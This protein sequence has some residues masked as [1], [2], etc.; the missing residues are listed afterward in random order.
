[1]ATVHS[2]L[3]QLW[4]D[5]NTCILLFDAKYDKLHRKPSFNETN[6]ELE[7]NV[8][9]SAL[10]YF[11]NTLWIGTVD[12][13]LMLY[14]VKEKKDEISIDNLSSECCQKVESPEC[15]IKYPTGKRIS[16]DFNLEEHANM[17]YHMKNICYIPTKDEITQAEAMREDDLVKNDER[18]TRY[19]VSLEPFDKDCPSNILDKRRR[20]S[21][22]YGNTLK[23]F[24]END[25]FCNN[26]KKRQAVLSVKKYCNLKP[27]SS[28]SSIGN[29]DETNSRTPI[30]RKYS[31]AKPS[32][33]M[34]NEYDINSPSTGFSTANQSMEFDD[35]FE[36]YSD[37]DL[38][39]FADTSGLAVDFLAERTPINKT[40]QIPRRK[41]SR[42]PRSIETNDL[43]LQSKISEASD[44]ED[45]IL[46]KTHLRRKDLEFEDNRKPSS[47]QDR[48]IQL[49]LLMK[50]KIS[51][52]SIQSI[53]ASKANDED[54]VLTGT[55][56]Y[57]TSEEALLIWRQE[58][59]TKLWINDPIED[60]SL[61]KILVG[62][63]SFPFAFLQTSAS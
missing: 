44:D 49:E 6:D 35:L 4:S 41:L 9:I 29:N 60:K 31:S 37:E 61:R 50:L 18:T 12:G 34:A 24:E 55:G 16:P 26:G 48:N 54:I 42:N 32:I 21:A 38:N 46:N 13:Y 57:N 30:F 20:R 19:S 51:D 11:N 47:V 17:P 1:M 10:M 45:N 2:S 40:V 52:E 22:F 58:P 43:L 53:I 28:N 59:A 63:K 23:L 8:E 5:D 7:D 33:S 25:E 36:I 14:E 15:K 27:I 3:V 56:K 62:K 39:L